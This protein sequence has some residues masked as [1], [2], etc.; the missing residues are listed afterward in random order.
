MNTKKKKE[1][2]PSHIYTQ[3][4]AHFSA[5]HIQAAENQQQREIQKAKERWGK[6]R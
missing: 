5:N 3:R 6:D 1:N 4:G 2:S